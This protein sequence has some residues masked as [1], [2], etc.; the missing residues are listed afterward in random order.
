VLKSPARPGRRVAGS[1]HKTQ[2]H[3]NFIHSAIRKPGYWPNQHR[4]NCGTVR[5]QFAHQAV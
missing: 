3:N 4:Q 1:W 5:R 2:K